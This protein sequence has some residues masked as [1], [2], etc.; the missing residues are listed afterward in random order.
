MR[1]A[2]CSAF[3]FFYIPEWENILSG[4]LKIKSSCSRL[5]SCSGFLVYRLIWKLCHPIAL[6]VCR[7]EHC[8]HLTLIDSF[9]VELFTFKWRMRPVNFLCLGSLSKVGLQSQLL[10]GSYEAGLVGIARASR[11][12]HDQLRAAT[13]YTHVAMGTVFPSV[14]RSLE[15][16]RETGN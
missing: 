3:N 11:K 8:E 10:I 15:F 2:L 6:L 16:S 13:V 7:G 9:T 4:L 1:A 12:V 14:A 5:T